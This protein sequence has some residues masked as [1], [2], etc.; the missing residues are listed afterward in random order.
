MAGTLLAP[1]GRVLNYL[2]LSLTDLCNL[3]CRYCM[4]PNGVAKLSHADILSYEEILRLLRVA[5]SLGVDKLRLTGG[6]PLVRRGLTHFIKRLGDEGLFTQMR[7]TTNGVLL[8]PLAAELK[9]AGVSGL[10]ISL[11]ALDADVYAHMSGQPLEHGRGLFEKSRAGFLAA[12]E[13]GFTTKINCVPIRG[14]NDSQ[15]LPLARLA[16][17]YPVTVRFIEHMPIG[18]DNIWQAAAFMSAAELKETIE[19]ELGAMAE[20]PPEYPSAPARLFKPAGAAGAIGFISPLSRHFCAACNR[21]RLTADGRLKPCLLTNQEFDLRAPLRHGA[22]DSELK[23]IFLNATTQKPLNHQSA[24]PEEADC[25][26]Q[27]SRIGG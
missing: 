26:R 27:M 25:R 1:G 16:L 10:N 14:Q 8:A 13:H 3:R 23:D 7:L 19:Q 17:Q 11:D 2:R 22:S 6:E 15:V 4:P 12:L 9:R 20:M 24:P 18:P 21:L 5:S